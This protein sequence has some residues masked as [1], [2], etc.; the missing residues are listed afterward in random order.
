MEA[1]IGE[2]G[3]G[4]LRS[5]PAIFTQMFC[6]AN[7]LCEALGLVSNIDEVMDLPAA[8]GHLE[9]NRCPDV[10]KLE[11]NERLVPA[12]QNVWNYVAVRSAIMR[13]VVDGTTLSLWAK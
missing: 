10:L 1:M 11:R 2:D 8:S 12:P 6:Y 9:I 3:I 4:G 13:R 5:T 7:R